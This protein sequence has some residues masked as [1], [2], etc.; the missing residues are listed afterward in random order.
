MRRI[1]AKGFTLIEI[2]IVVIIL[3][4]LAAIVIPQFSNASQQAHGSADAV[5]M[6]TMQAMIELYKLQHVG[7]FPTADGNAPGDLDWSLIDGKH[8]GS[9]GK[10][11]GPYISRP[12]KDDAGNYWQA[13]VDSDGRFCWGAAPN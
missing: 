13:Y 12:P 11:Y 4:I 10:F 1:A 5:D 7:N 3:G 9:D 8:I 6:Q 2:L